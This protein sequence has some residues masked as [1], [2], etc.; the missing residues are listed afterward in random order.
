[1]ERTAGV[2]IG[3]DSVLVIKDRWRRATDPGRRRVVAATIG[4]LRDKE[5]G[6]Q[7]GSQFLGGWRRGEGK[8]TIV[9]IALAV[10]SLGWIPK[11]VLMER[12]KVDQSLAGPSFAA[13]E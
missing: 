4:R 5:V 12:R 2:G 7:P 1:V 3:S 9:G 10:E 8:R 6:L 13:I 11:A